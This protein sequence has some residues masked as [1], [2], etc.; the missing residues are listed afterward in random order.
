MLF[1]VTFTG[2]L[3]AKANEKVTEIAYGVLMA[4]VCEVNTGCGGTTRIIHLH[5]AMESQAID[6]SSAPLPGN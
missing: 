4:K 5:I 3:G 6:I 1:S 2:E